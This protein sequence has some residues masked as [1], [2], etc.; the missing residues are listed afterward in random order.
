M[1]ASIHDV[2]KR[3]G[4]SIATVSRVIN[5]SAG[6]SD[7]KIASVTEAIEYYNFQPSQL[8]K[9]LVSGNSMTIGVYSPFYDGSMFQ[10]GYMLECLRGIEAEI[11]ES[12]YSL[13]LINEIKA[14]SQ[15]RKSAP[16][17][18]EYI[19]RKKLDGLILLAVPDDRRFRKYLES[20]LDQ[21][22]PVG[23]IGKR[24]HDKGINVYA[25]YELYMLEAVEQLYAKGHRRIVLFPSAN[26]TETTSF[27]KESAETR[28]P[29][30]TLILKETAMNMD[31]DILAETVKALIIRENV[32]GIITEDLNITA[33]INSILNSIGKKIGD[34]IS[35]ISVEHIR[36]TGNQMLPR[37]NC[38]YVP[39]LEMGKS[40]AR[41]IL[42][43]LQGQ[44]N[45][46]LSVTFR[47]EY[48]DR[49]S[50]KSCH[51]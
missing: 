36:D 6:V 22:F 37:I 51:E 2:A 39:A 24:F 15:N 17:F 18:T 46:K 25:E 10:S 21:D 34:D 47:P 16:K 7:H 12:P 33:S 5:H 23:Y 26:R 43:W 32:T 38:F 40:V 49:G 48:M 44:D 41:G 30:L 28:H 50:V 9:A 31:M 27:L 3:A 14:Y 20:V 29:D 8:G 4:V 13:L 11:M 19:S 1:G 35:L 45:S 42:E